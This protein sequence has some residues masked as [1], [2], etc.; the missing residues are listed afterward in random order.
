VTHRF[1]TDLPTLERLAQ[2]GEVSFEDLYED[3]A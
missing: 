3:T 1:V 2:V